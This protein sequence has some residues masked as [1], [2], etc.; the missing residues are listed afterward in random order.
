MMLEESFSSGK[1]I[2]HK[3][4]ARIK[5]IVAC[6]YILTLVLSYDLDRVLIL[7][8][9]SCHILEF[10]SCKKCSGLLCIR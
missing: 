7:F 1:S 8:I 3:A 4:D 9:F 6:L 2:F 10:D 5:I